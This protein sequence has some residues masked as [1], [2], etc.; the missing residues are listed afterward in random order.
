MKS[1]I[2]TIAFD[3]DDTLWHN[4]TYFQQAELAFCDL[5][6][7]YMDQSEVS[8]ILLSIEVKNLPLYGYGVKG[9]VL[10]M[11]EAANKISNFSVSGESIG[12]IVEIG[13]DL[14]NKPTMLLDGVQESL[15]QLQPNYRL[16]LA[17]KGDLLDQQSKLKKSGLGA[18]FD[19]VEIM[20]N[21]RVDDYQKLLKQ[22]NCQPESFLMVGNSLRSDIQPV[23]ALGSSTVY[24]PYHITWAH[25]EQ[26]VSDHFFDELKSFKISEVIEILPFLI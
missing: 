19:H 23:L 1:K 24:I 14:L 2:K 26:G 20:S 18:Y 22:L 15:D 8:K 17:T 10:C 3:G 12:R 21:K 5:L 13:Q 6:A 16:V 7:D 9:F 11:I 4:E 25:E